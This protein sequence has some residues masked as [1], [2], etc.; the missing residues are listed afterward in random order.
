[1]YSQKYPTFLYANLPPTSANLHLATSFNPRKE[2]PLPKLMQ[3]R[4][5]LKTLSH[6]LP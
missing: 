4:I 1:M 2:S 6:N 3:Q 5:K